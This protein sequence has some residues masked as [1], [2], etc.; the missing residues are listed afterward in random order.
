MRNSAHFIA[1]A[2]FERHQ[3]NKQK[4]A[5][6]FNR[7]KKIQLKLSPMNIQSHI[8]AVSDVKLVLILV[9]GLWKPLQRPLEDFAGCRRCCR[10]SYYH[11]AA[12][13]HSP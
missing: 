1:S 11:S 2:A 12:T 4:V 13:S 8:I 6:F 10:A 3:Q 5:H 9:W 7:E